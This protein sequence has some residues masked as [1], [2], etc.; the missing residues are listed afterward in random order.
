M[1][2]DVQLDT[3]TDK[4]IEGA[5]AERVI[6]GDKASAEANPDPICLTSFGVDSTGPPA[7]SC[8]RY[9]ALVNKGAA[10]PKPCLSP[11]KVRTRTATGGLLPAGIAS[12]A[13]MVIFH[14]SPLWLCLTEEI[15]SRTSN[16]YATDYSSCWNIE[17]LEIK[18]KE[19]LTFYPSGYSGCLLG[20]CRALLC[21]K[22]FVW[23][24]DGT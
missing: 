24:T 2:A 18:T 23:A 21:E 19:I 9:G 12:T 1:E 3:E 16:Q 13:T 14:Q 17:V 5:A 11:V 6:R 15:K 10:A 7:L 22:V 4:R 20:A 8:S